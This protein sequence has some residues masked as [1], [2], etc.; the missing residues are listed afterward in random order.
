NLIV[1]KN[2]QGDSAVVAYDV[3]NRPTTRRLSPVI[4]DNTTELALYAAPIGQAAVK[5]DTVSFDYDVMGRPTRI[6][7]TDVQINRTY[8]KQGQLLTDEQFLK[9]DPVPS[10]AHYL[11]TYT[12]SINGARKT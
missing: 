6:E 10:S 7:N 2:R 1:L 9:F 12:Y 11:Y 5:G 4:S 3:L 8:S